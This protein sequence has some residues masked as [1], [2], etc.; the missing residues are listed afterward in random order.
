VQLTIGPDTAAGQA[1][2]GVDVGG[3][4]TDVHVVWGGREARGKAL[5]TY[6]DFSRG[7]L[8][9]VAVGAENLEVQ[10]GQLLAETKLFVNATTVVTN[11][12]TSLEGSRV[13]VLVTAGFRDE[14]RFAGG[15][16]LRVVD[17]HLQTNVP[18]LFDRRDL[19]EIDERIDYTG[20]VL[21][22][23]VDEQVANAARH[24]VEERR[25]ETIAVCFLSSYANSSHEDRAAQ[26]ITERYPDIFVTTSSKVSSVLG[27]YPRWITAVLNAFVHRN[28]EAFLDTLSTKLYAAGL[29]GRVAFFQGSAAASAPSGRHSYR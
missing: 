8:E 4:H 5:T 3:T 24:L 1:F 22:P 25:V 13:G 23:L 18:D 27:E 29:S 21:V 26:I 7:V 19:I 6:D 9:A 20:S 10:P 17:D 2:I 15:P 12:I 14:F 11:A 28:A 16:R